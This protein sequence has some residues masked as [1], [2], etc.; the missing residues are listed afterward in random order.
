[1]SHDK[2]NITERLRKMVQERKTPIVETKRIIGHK[3]SRSKS[4]NFTGEV[5]SHNYDD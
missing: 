1:M 3:P 2:I 5:Y 4:S